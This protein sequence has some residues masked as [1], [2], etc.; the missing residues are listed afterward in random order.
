V[1]PPGAQL[2]Q[3]LNIDGVEP[4]PQALFDSIRELVRLHR[5]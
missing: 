5:R 3:R 4:A 2:L 1:Q